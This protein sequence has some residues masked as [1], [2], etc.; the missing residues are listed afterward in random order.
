MPQGL[1]TG[2]LFSNNIE[3]PLD[4]VGEHLTYNPDKNWGNL[5]ALIK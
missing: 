3:S 1:G 5:N 4:V 2:S